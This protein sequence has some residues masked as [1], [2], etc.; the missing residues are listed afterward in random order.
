MTWI[1]MDFSVE[2]DA[3]DALL[4]MRTNDTDVIVLYITLLWTLTTCQTS[5]ICCTA[6]SATKKCKESHPY[7]HSWRFIGKKKT[8]NN[9]NPTTKTTAT[10][11]AWP[12]NLAIH[13]KREVWRITDFLV[14]GLFESLHFIQVCIMP[15]FSL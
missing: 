6:F 14:G 9:T 15:H 10:K 7:R 8:T 4:R 13:R 3:N 1:L 11:K 2:R 5:R 12:K